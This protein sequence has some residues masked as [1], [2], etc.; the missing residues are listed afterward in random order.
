MKRKKKIG[1]LNYVIKKEKLIL[2]L[3]VLA[4]EDLNCLGSANFNKLVHSFQ[5]DPLWGVRLYWAL[6][7]IKVFGKRATSEHPE[8]VLSSKAYEMFDKLVQSFQWAPLWGVRLC[9]VLYDI[10]FLGKRATNEHPEEVLSS[11][12][13]KILDKLV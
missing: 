12:A 1:Y 11:E 5:W 7:D 4:L 6:Y 10:K 8:E 2:V 9:W 3:S 13:S